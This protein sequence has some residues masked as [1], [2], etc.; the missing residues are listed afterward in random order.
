M[1]AIRE[2]YGDKG[3]VEE[4]L[5]PVEALVGAVRRGRG[6]GMDKRERE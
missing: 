6:K 3:V 1:R 4:R 5:G 2:Y